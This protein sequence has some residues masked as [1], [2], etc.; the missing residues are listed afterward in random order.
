MNVDPDQFVAEIGGQG[1][2]S[3]FL[4]SGFG[5]PRRPGMTV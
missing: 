2:L 4:D 3:V 1:R 5:P